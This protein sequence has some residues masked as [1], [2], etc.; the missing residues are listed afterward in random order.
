MNISLGATNNSAIS[1]PALSQSSGSGRATPARATTAGVEDAAKPSSGDAAI[2]S[3]GSDVEQL[4]AQ[5]DAM[6][7]TSGGRVEQLRTM[8][9]QGTYA[10]NPTNV[11]NA[12]FTT[13]F[14]QS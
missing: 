11:A 12:M 2:V 10:V 5:L 6:P 13:L 1:D 4:K 14:G 8:I 3:L 7:G 9:A